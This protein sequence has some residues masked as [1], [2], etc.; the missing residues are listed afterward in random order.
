MMEKTNTTKTRYVNSN[1]LWYFEQYNGVL[2][3]GGDGG[4]M[5][6]VG[7]RWWWFGSGICGNGVSVGDG[8]GGGGNGCVGGD[9]LIV[10]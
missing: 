4:C 8:G 5:L 9:R 3:G 7:W 1:R 10:E 2:G 6:F